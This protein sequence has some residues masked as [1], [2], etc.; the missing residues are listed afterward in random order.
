M[1]EVHFELI[2]LISI[3]NCLIRRDSFVL[4]DLPQQDESP[5]LHKIAVMVLWI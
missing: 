4:C 3:E 1:L 2:F 5:E